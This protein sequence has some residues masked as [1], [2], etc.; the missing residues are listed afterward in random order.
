MP[1]EPGFEVWRC[2]T[3]D[4]TDWSRVVDNGLG[5]AATGGDGGLVVFNSQLYFVVSNNATGAEGSVPHHLRW[6]RLDASG[7]CGLWR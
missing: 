4:G 3:C 2:Q 1:A 6:H 7:L 5:H